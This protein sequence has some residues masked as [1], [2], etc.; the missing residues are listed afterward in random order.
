MQVTCACHNK[1]KIICRLCKA[2]GYCSKRC[3]IQDHKYHKTYCARHRDLQ[4][5]TLSLKEYYVHAKQP[6]CQALDAYVRW[7]A[8]HPN[9]V[10]EWQRLALS[11]MIFEANRSIP[12]WSLIAK[13]HV[14]IN[15]RSG[16]EELWTSY[17]NLYLKQ[18]SKNQQ[19]MKYVTK[20]WSTYN[21]VSGT[22]MYSAKNKTFIAIMIP[23]LDF[24]IFGYGLKTF[25]D[26][27]FPA[28]YLYQT[29]GFNKP[30]KVM[31]YFC[32]DL[33][34]MIFVIA[35]GFM[36]KFDSTMLDVIQTYIQSSALES[37]TF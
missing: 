18:R 35:N 8:I 34:M 31:K 7:I 29:E 15:G 10:N 33:E 26:N 23:I 36:R 30:G 6:I 27:G 5:N 3:Q 24:M 13:H 9:V 14:H 1:I 4:T 25:V 28:T 11:H 16:N 22:I 21:P 20:I 17:L 37:I 19:I 32:S 2:K 12:D